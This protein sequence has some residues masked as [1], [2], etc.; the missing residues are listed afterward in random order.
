MEMCVVCV[1]VKQTTACE[2]RISDWSSDLCSSDL[3][4]EVDVGRGQFV[5]RSIGAN[6]NS[7][8]IRWDEKQS[9]P[10]VALHPRSD[11]QVIGL[12]AAEHHRLGAIE[13]IAGDRK[14]VV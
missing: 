10:G 8:G 7:V 13:D 14:S 12:S 1:F 5:D 2:L 9:G 3:A 4:S 6:G 11:N